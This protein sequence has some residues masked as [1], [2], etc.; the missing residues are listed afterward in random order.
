MARATAPV[1]GAKAD[2]TLW[3]TAI[4]TDYVS[5]T[6]TTNQNMASNLIFASGKAPSYDGSPA[7]QYRFVQAGTSPITITHGIGQAPTGVVATVKGVQ[8][9]AIGVNWSAT[10]ITVY[11]SAIGSVTV[12]VIAWV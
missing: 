1:T 6:E 7:A 11:H 4:N 2:P 5:Q 8:P 10:N 12:S 3:P 9:Y